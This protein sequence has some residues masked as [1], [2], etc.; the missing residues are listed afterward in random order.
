M[1]VKMKQ[2]YD[3]DQK[4]RTFAQEERDALAE[5]INEIRRLDALDLHHVTTLSKAVRQTSKSRKVT[6]E[7][8]RQVI[9]KL[10]HRSEGLR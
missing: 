7:E 5:L 4:I 3:I 8:K 10:E 2:A 6:P 9:E 1:G